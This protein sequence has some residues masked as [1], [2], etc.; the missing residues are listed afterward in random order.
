MSDHERWAREI[1]VELD[2][3]LTLAEQ[4]ALARHVAVCPTCAGTR[5]S[6]LELRASLARASGHPRAKII[7][8]Q[9]LRGRTLALLTL[10][11]ALAGA[12]GGWLAH[13]RWGGPGAG[14]L[15]ASRATIDIR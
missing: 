4:A 14:G 7:P 11:A 3:D 6:H 15:E 5:A 2:G 8:R 12:G 9:V 1:E 10:L 13:A